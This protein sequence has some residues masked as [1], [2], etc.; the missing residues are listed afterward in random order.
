LVSRITSETWQ[1]LASIRHTIGILGIFRRKV[2]RVELARMS[3]RHRNTQRPGR[4][5]LSKPKRSPGKDAGMSLMRVKDQTT[6]FRFPLD[7][8]REART[9]RPI[10]GAWF[11]FNPAEEHAKRTGRSS[12]TTTMIQD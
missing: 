11:D 8:E 10:R 1:S 5:K 12:S 4:L 9:P 3:S 6:K 2:V 7:S